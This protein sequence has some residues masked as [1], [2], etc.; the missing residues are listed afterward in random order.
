MEHTAVLYEAKASVIDMLINYIG[1]K[2]DE[3][4]VISPTMSSDYSLIYYYNGWKMVPTEDLWYWSPEWQ[5]KEAEAFN[6]IKEGH[7]ESF[8]SIDDFFN[9]MDE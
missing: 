7:I 2:E 5:R 1:K 9:S 4:T 3:N 8:D 6:D